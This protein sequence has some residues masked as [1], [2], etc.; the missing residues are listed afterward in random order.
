M[1]ERL[2]IMEPDNFALP[3]PDFLIA[4]PGD[5]S[6]LW[7]PVQTRRGCPMRCS[8]CSTG[9]IEGTIT[10]K[11]SLKNVVEWITKLESRGVKQFYFVDN[12]FN[13]PPSY[14]TA[15]CRELAKASLKLKWRCILYPYHLDES[16]V[17]AMAGAGCFEAAV[18]FESGNEKVLKAMNKRFRLEDVAQACSLLKRYGIRQMGFLLLGG[19][20]ETRK[21]VEESLSFA[22]FL[23]LES[24]RVTVGIR[25]Y[26]GT[27]LAEQARREGVIATDDDLFTPKFYVTPGLEDEIREAVERYAA[28]RPQWIV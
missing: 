26:P 8:Y 14:A 1:A 18:G 6:D 24:M 20:G 16:L 17:E 2:L 23:D 28:K 27:A 13:L 5:T 22:D 7:I 25:I 4:A 15:L 19:P 21:S 3:D 11:R 10:R 12:T 9:T